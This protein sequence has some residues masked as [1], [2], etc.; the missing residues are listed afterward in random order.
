MELQ[1]I[2]AVMNPWESKPFVRY[3]RVHY[4]E[5][6]LN[7]TGE[8]ADT[9]SPAVRADSSPSSSAPR[10]DSSSVPGAGG[11]LGPLYTNRA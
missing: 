11:A 5:R 10:A 6:A 8:A 2:I 3:S 7:G 4:N 1:Y 9:S